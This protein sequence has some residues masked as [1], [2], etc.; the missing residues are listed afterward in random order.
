MRKDY[1]AQNDTNYHFYRG[2]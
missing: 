1:V 2:K